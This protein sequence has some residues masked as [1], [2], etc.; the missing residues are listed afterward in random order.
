L[1]LT[2]PDLDNHRAAL[3][4][5]EEVNLLI[6]PDFVQ[7]IGDNAQHAT[8]DQFRLFRQLAAQVKAPYYALVGDHDLDEAKSC[9]RFVEHV[10]DPYGS[11]ESQGIRFIRLNSQESR[12][13]GFTEDQLDWLE[14]EFDLAAERRQKVLIFQHNYPFQI[15]EDFNGPGIDR[16]RSIMQSR[17][18]VAIVCGHT[19][20][21]QIA[22]DGRITSVAVRSIGDPEGGAPGYLLGFMH[23]DDL[24]FKYRTIEDMGPV[25]M[26]THPRNLLLATGSGHI[27]HV[28]DEIHARTWS[29]EPLSKVQCRIDQ[30][31]VFDMRTAGGNAWT[32][33]LF[34]DALAKGEHQ[35]DILAVG[36]LGDVVATDSLTFAF[37]PTNRYTAVP[38]AWPTVKETAYC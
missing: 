15:W 33:P 13:V 30:G 5:I 22:N 31:R 35:L 37:D 36:P 38:M 23:G 32:A 14:Q 26:I 27:V 25:A 9:D 10:G 1:H 11:N 28:D 19:H 3:R 6:Q 7:F 2:E 8:H 4:I 20:Y 12:P 18:P 21:W 17:C 24:A 34:V 16:W 29:R